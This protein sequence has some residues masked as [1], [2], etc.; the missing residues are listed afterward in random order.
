VLN[1]GQGHLLPAS[2]VINAF[3]VHGKT[4]TQVAEQLSDGSGAAGAQPPRLAE[5]PAGAAIRV[6]RL[7]EWDVSAQGRQPVSLIVQYVIAVP[8]SGQA[9]VLTFSTPA[10]GLAEQLRPVFHG[11]AA[12]LQFAGRADTLRFGTPRF[13]PADVRG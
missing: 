2:L 1:D 9:L 3:P 6:E 13:D 10:L 8:G 7:R 11:I 5:L 12:T 4:L